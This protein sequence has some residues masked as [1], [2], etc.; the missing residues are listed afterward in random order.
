MAAWQS[1]RK[2]AAERRDSLEEA[3]SLQRYLAD[4]RDLISWI[5]DTRAVIGADELAKDVAGAEALVERHHEHKGEIDAR[6][7]SFKACLQV[8]DWLHRLHKF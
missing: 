5:H 1:L 4:Y 7:D 3:H 8:T 6:A 2:K